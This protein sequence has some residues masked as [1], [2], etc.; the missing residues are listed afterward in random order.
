[1]QEREAFARKAE[2][3]YQVDGFAAPGIVGTL[4]RLT[5]KVELVHEARG[6]LRVEGNPGADGPMWLRPEGGPGRYR[7]A[8]NVD[9]ATNAVFDDRPDGSHLW[10]GHATLLRPA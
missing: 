1:M 10:I 9:H 7:V 8:S 4:A 5:T 6:L 2:G 3:R